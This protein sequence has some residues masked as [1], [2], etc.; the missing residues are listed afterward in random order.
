MS[1][2]CATL[3]AVF[4]PISQGSFTLS[5]ENSSLAGSKPSTYAGVNGYYVHVLHFA[6]VALTPRTIED[7]TSNERTDHTDQNNV[8]DRASWTARAVQAAWPPT[9]IKNR[10]GLTTYG[11]VVWQVRKYA[12]QTRHFRSFDCDGQVQVHCCGDRLT[13]PCTHQARSYMYN[14]SWT[15]FRDTGSCWTLRGPPETRKALYTTHVHVYD[16]LRNLTSSLPL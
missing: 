5:Y 2:L 15:Q 10:T 9:Q 8:Q 12:G 1:T 11:R 7:P 4:Q 3:T 16:F 14:C 6:G 13:W